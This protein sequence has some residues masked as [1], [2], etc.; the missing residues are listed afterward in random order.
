MNKNHHSAADAEATLDKIEYPTIYIS[1]SAALKV[2]NGK[3]NCKQKRQ[4]R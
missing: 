4:R 1:L 2:G 3:K